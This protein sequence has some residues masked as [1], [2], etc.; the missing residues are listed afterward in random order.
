MFVNGLVGL[1]L[2]AFLKPE[3]DQLDA[4][5]GETNPENSIVICCPL[6]QHDLNGLKLLISLQTIRSIDGAPISSGKVKVI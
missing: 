3:I 5:V 6:A 1:V 4:E 2:G